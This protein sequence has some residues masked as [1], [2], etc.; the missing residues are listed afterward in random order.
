MST[1]LSELAIKSLTWLARAMH[2]NPDLCYATGERQREKQ[3]VKWLLTRLVQRCQA[4]RNSSTKGYLQV[5]RSPLS[6]WRRR[7]DQSI[8]GCYHRADAPRND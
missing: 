3:P 8:L 4:K 7:N 6:W 1:E 2:S 5:F